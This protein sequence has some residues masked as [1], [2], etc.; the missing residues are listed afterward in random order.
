MK[1]GFS[2]ATAEIIRLSSYR[3]H[4]STHFQVSAEEFEPA[5]L[6]RCYVCIHSS[7]SGPS[8]R[9]PLPLHYSIDCIN[10]PLH[11]HQLHPHNSIDCINQSLSSRIIGSAFAFSKLRSYTLNILSWLEF[12]RAITVQTFRFRQLSQSENIRKRIH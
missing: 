12:V 2:L 4:Q 3:L 1:I 10:Q 6:F 5:T 9:S 8:P 11:L 7:F